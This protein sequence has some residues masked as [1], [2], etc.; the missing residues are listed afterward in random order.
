[1]FSWSEIWQI[2]K[3]QWRLV[4]ALFGLVSLVWGMFGG[5][6]NIVAALDTLTA[7]IN[8]L[9]AL[10]Q[11]SPVHTLMN[12]LNR[13]FPLSE[14]LGFTSMWFGMWFAALVIRVAR[15]FLPTIG[16]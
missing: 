12:R 10:L 6:D 11:A 16:G 7:Q 13:V 4:V 15:S 5:A 2:A 14:L 8:V 1:M 9:S 3:A